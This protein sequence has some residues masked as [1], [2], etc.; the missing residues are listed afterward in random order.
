MATTSFHTE[1]DFTEEVAPDEDLMLE[2][3]GRDRRGV[4]REMAPLDAMERGTRKIEEGDGVYADHNTDMATGST[5]VGEVLG[6]VDIVRYLGDE[7]L[8]PRMTH[9]MTVDAEDL[10]LGGANEKVQRAQD[11][12]METFDIQADL[13]FLKGITNEQGSQVQPGIFDWLDNNIPSGN[14]INAADY[15][16]DYSLSNGQPSNII[17]RIAYQK[18]QGI[19]ADDAWDFVMWK[20]PVR[21]LW[22]TIDDNSGVNLQSQ[23]VDMGEDQAG[24]GNSVVGDAITVPNNIG[25]RTAPDAPDTLQF[26]IDFPTR[27]N[28]SYSSPL[29]GAEFPNFDASDDAM[30]LIPEHNGDFFTMYE[31]PEPT[32]IQEPIRKN[33]GQLEYE[34]YWRAG[35]AFGF[36]SHKTDDGAGGDIAYDAVKIENVSALF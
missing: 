16:S 31:Q 28:T 15:T 20:H 9:G 22:N 12:V 25:L 18:T 23:W 14:V 27:Q 5:G 4:R 2:R 33:G 7:V 1:D 3:E 21:A 10:E 36:G 24:V 29:G 17:Q 26:D 30:Y 8:I 34:F 32:M 13:Q 6:N 19:Y 35:Q 11:V